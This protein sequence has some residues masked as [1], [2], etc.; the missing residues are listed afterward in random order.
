MIAIPSTWHP[1]LFL[2][3]LLLLRN[4]TEQCLLPQANHKKEFW[5]HKPVSDSSAAP[6]TFISESL[7]PHYEFCTAHLPVS[8]TLPLI[9]SCLLQ[10]PYC[11]NLSLVVLILCPHLLSLS[12]SLYF[13]ALVSA[14]SGIVIPF[15][16]Y[17]KV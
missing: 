4:S 12:H 10:V 15:S 6:L 9:Y 2:L 14:T 3:Q 1:V 7:S 17:V 13:A 16:V 8:A 11:P 5:T